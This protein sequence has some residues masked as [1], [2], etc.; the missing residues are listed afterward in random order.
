MDDAAR[1]KR[2]KIFCL[3]VDLCKQRTDP[4]RKRVTGGNVI[5]YGMR[6]K[7]HRRSRDRTDN[8]QVG[9]TIT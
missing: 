5:A 7:L 4:M 1:M 2:Y 9:K 8:I 6:W 3:W